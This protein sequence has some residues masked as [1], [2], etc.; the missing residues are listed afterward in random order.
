[1]PRRRPAWRVPCVQQQQC[2]DIRIVNK[3]AM[4]I[5]G[6]A[7]LCAG[8]AAAENLSFSLNVQVAPVC[9]AFG[10]DG[11]A[12]DVDF[13]ALANI[14]A[15]QTVQ[16]RAGRIIYRC[17][18]AVGYTRTIASQNGGYLTL[19]GNPTTDDARRIPF[20][21]RTT[22]AHRF[23]PI[24]LLS[25]LST[26]HGVGQNSTAMLRGN[27]GNVFFNAFGVRGPDGPNGTP[28]TTVFAGNYRDTVTVTVTAN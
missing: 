6:T 18:S 7:A 16:R 22:G 19:D 17:N 8:G 2:G 24:Q 9:G 15:D 28:G 11:P 20:T 10:T 14:P 3:I 25:P 4:L 12:I 26:F 21:M 23:G 27:G 5:A 1:M 13:G